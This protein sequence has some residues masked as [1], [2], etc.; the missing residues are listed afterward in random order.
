[1]QRG[2][3][4]QAVAGIV[5]TLAVSAGLEAAHAA[6]APK[7]PNA[8]PARRASS[9]RTEAVAQAALADQVARH[10]DR[11]R[12]VLAMIAAARML[13]QTGPRT[14]KPE[15]RTEGKPKR[16]DPSAGT[17]APSRDTTLKG[18]LE[19][20]RKYAGG[21]HDFNI[22]VDE[23]AESTAK[24]RKD[25][26]ARFAHRIAPGVTD[27]YTMSFRADEP[28][29][30]AITGEGVSDLDLFVED[31]AGNRICASDGAGDDEMCRWTPRWNG[32]FRIRVRNVGKV[33]NEYRIWSN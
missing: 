24:V 32:N 4:A 15:L 11:T 31:E 2:L 22:L 5:A 1:M 23:L 6:G 3:R 9:P 14:V 29:L 13:G 19:R 12:D 18:M 17:P 10:A 16:A 20:A 8:D 30:V 7:G 28:V 25:G 26:P 27:V 21:R 33:E